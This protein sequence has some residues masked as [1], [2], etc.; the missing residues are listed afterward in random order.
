[1]NNWSLVALAGV[2]LLISRQPVLLTEENE[3]HGAHIQRSMQVYKR[4]KK[5]HL[6]LTSTNDYPL[7]VLLAGQ[8]EH[9]ETLMDRVERL[10]QKIAASS[11][12]NI[13]C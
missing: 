4:M 13:F 11:A 1:M 7:A 12:N 2:Y 8:S 5:D 6:F 9:V 10:Y 3:Q